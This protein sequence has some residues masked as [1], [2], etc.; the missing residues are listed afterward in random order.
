MDNPESSITLTWQL[1]RHSIITIF[2]GGGE[3]LPYYSKDGG[4]MFL[5]NV[6]NHLQKYLGHNSEGCNHN[7]HRFENLKFHKNPQVRFY[8]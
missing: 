6:G 1:Y 2:Q 7:F 8:I 4:E 5:R 3:L